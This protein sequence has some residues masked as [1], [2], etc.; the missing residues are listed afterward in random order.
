MATKTARTKVPGQITCEADIASGMRA[1]RR[2]C[3]FARQMHDVAGTPPVRVNQPGF[4][5][6][7]RIIV[8]QQLSVAS[9]GAIWARCQ[10][11]LQPFTPDRI[12]RAR[13]TTMRAA[14]LSAGKVRTLK[15]AAK[16][17]R[18]GDLILEPTAD[19]RDD[20]IVDSLVAVTGIGPWT[21]DIYLMFA[22][23]RP[24]AFAPG[25]LAL[26]IG[27]QYGFA[28][29]E[30]PSPEELIEIVEGWRP[31]RGVGARLLWHYYAAV[32][33]QKTEVIPV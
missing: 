21:A 19:A 1:L 20:E 11:R 23:G 4:E 2:A 33:Q 27:A 15:A 16:A 5:G 18:T 9:A 14:G 24:D 29:D 17:A 28:L 22:L 30:R 32:K 3:R 7:A 10:E 8:G 26:Q 31:W 6:L 25:D 12:V 13:E